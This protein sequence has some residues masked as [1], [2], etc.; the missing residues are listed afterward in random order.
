MSGVDVDAEMGA[1]LAA[2]RTEFDQLK[3]VATGAPLPVHA[4]RA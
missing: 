4:E 1:E 2:L 3:P